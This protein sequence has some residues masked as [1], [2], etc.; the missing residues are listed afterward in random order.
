MVTYLIDLILH[1][2]DEPKYDFFLK[3]IYV[4]P[5]ISIIFTIW[6]VYK[7]KNTKTSE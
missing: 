6:D 3:N 1:S 5:I 4:A 7:K 2:K